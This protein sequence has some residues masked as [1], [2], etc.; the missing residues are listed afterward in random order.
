MKEEQ[1]G[2]KK[3]RGFT[4]KCIYKCIKSGSRSSFVAV[5]GV[6]KDG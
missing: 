1:V 3:G 6:G 2:S 5:F 4:L